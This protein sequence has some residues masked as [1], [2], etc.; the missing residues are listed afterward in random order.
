MSKFYQECTPKTIQAWE[1]AVKKNPDAEWH[2]NKISKILPF[3]KKVMPR[4]GNGQSLFGLSIV[5]L[6]VKPKRKAYEEKIVRYGLEPLLKANILTEEEAGKI[7]QWFLKTKPT[8]NSGG[9]GYFTKDFEIDGTKYRLIT[10]SY[11]GFRDLNI[12]I[13][14]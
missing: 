4:I 5:C 13:L 14:H 7:V 8:W 1:E 12:Q 6:S 11:R 9:A 3:L 2:F 10:D